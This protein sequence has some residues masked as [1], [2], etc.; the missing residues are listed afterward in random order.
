MNDGQSLIQLSSA[1]KKKLNDVPH[2][3]AF[4]AIGNA[5]VNIDGVCRV[6]ASGLLFHIDGRST[7]VLQYR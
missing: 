5:I 1:S 7:S 6:S 2:T 3:L 4:T